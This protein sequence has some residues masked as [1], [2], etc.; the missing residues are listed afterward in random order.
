MTLTKSA[1]R[2]ALDDIRAKRPHELTSEHLEE[3]LELFINVDF[4]EIGNEL[5]SVQSALETAVSDI[6]SLRRSL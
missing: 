2:L 4:D 3:L 1:V 6:Q 5:Y